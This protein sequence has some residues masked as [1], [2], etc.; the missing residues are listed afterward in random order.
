MNPHTPF[1]Q[2]DARWQAQEAARL[3]AQ[4]G[5][6]AAGDADLLVAHALRRM[7][8]PGLPDDF[9]ANVARRAETIAGTHRADAPVAHRRDDAEDGATVETALTRTLVCGL[10]LAG[11]VV[12]WLQGAAW[13]RGFLPLA[14]VVPVETLGWIGPGLACI[15]ATAVMMRMASTTSSRHA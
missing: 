13:S 15:A 5:E 7:P 3:R 6:S 12:A 2:N 14:E 9:A 1:D 10:A 4:R 11:G 8:M